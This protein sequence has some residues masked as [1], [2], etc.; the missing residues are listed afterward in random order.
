MLRFFLSLWLAIVGSVFVLVGIGILGTYVLA[1]N[2]PAHVVEAPR[3]TSL[4]DLLSE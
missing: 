2:A 4:E 1:S 3:T